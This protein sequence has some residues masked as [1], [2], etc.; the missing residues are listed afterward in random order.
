MQEKYDLSPEK[1]KEMIQKKDKQR[2][3]YYNYFSSKKW[4]MSDSYHLSIDSSILGEEG[5]VELI[6]QFLNDF[7]KRRKA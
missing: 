5:T 2:S 6:I 7:E 4:G 1:A 3:N